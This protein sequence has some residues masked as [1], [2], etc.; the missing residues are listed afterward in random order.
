MKK[1]NCV[2]IL[3][4]V[5][6]GVDDSVALLYALLNPQVEV[7]GI[8]TVC[9]NVEAWLAAENTLKILDLAD[10]PDIPVVCGAEEPLEGTWEGRVAFIHGDNGL[11]NVELPKSSRQLAAE[12][13]SAFQMRMAEQ[14]EGELILV[15]LGPLTNIARTLEKY[16]DFAGK[17]KKMV[18]MGGTI[19]MRGNVSPVGEANVVADPKACDQVFLSGMDITT[20]G[21]DVTMKVR[22]KQEHI[23]WLDHCCSRRAR[24]AVEYIRKAMVH[25]FEGNQLQNYCMGD[26]PVHDPLAVMTAVVPSLVRVEQRKAR[27]ECGGTYC[28]GMIVTDLREHP[29]E[30]EY[31]G[32]AL[33][34]D[35]QRALREL[36][37]VFWETQEECSV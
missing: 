17:I 13:V 23:E 2:K 22:L 21:L 15:A 7:V 6:T 25:Y 35:E 31:V 1:R 32:F 14:Y 28:R 24:K 27:V 11:G 36:M 12:D 9:G 37:S 5:D 26:C 3:L 20:V 8:T 18:M 19:S 33:E 16:P 4:D 29:I 30:A 10:A 34:V